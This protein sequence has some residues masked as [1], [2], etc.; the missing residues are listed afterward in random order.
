MFESVRVALFAPATF[1]PYNSHWYVSGA[2]PAATTVNITVEPA[3]E[4]TLCGWVVTLGGCPT[5]RVAMLLMVLPAV[6]VTTQRTWS[7]LIGS[8]RALSV[9][10]ADCAPLTPTPFARSVHV[11]EPNDC[12]CHWYVK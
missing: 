3:A 4:L 10:P 8:V 2:V 11:P 6:F 9:R 12:R 5:V 1:T 7:P